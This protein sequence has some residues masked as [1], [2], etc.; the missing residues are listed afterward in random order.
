[1]TRGKE[2]DDGTKVRERSP[3]IGN[4]ASTDSVR[5]RST[6][7]TGVCSIGV[8][9]SS[10]NLLMEIDFS[11]S[12]LLGRRNRKHT[13]TWIPALVSCKRECEMKEAL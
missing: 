8:S 3:G 5:R 7:G 6:S 13:V 11:K 12:G 2:I 10:G 1:M 4:G 9:V